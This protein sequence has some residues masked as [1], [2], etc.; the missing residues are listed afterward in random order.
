MSPISVPASEFKTNF[1]YYLRNLGSQPVRITKNGKT[2]AE[3]NKVDPREEFMKLGGILKDS[4]YATWDRDK[5]RE[6]RLKERYG[7]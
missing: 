7:V 1:S 2:V 3:V 6:E 4:K 5:I